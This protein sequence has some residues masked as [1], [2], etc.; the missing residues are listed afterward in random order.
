[1]ADS[2]NLK[3]KAEKLAGFTCFAVALLM[4]LLVT[5]GLNAA[6]PKPR[7]IVTTDGEIDDFCSMT[8]FLLYTSDFDVEGLIYSSSIFHW[9]GHQWAGTNW[10]QEK[11]NLYGQSYSNLSA[12]KSGYPTAA[13]LL[14]KVYIG[15]INSAGDM[16]ADT[17]GSNRIVDVLRDG[18]PRP[19][20]ILMWGGTNTAA[21]ALYHIQQNYPSE[22]A[23]ISQKA[24]L[25]IGL[26]QDNTLESY[27]RPN[28]PDL[29]VIC[30]Y[31]IWMAIGYVPQ[32]YVSDSSKLTYYSDSWM[33]SNITSNHGPLLSARPQASVGTF[34]G[35]GDSIT[36]LYLM[37]VGFFNQSNPGYGC[38][39]GRYKNQ[40]NSS[41]YWEDDWDDEEF[42][43]S[44]WR[45]IDAYQNDYAARADWCVKAYANCNHPP[46]VNDYE[47]INSSPGQ[48]VNLTVSASDP[49]GNALSYQ[50]WYYKEAGSY[51]GSAI[52][53]SNATSSNASFTVPS[54]SG[55]GQVIHMICSVT[56][57]GTPPLTRYRRVIINVTSGTPNIPALG[58]FVMGINF[59]GNAVTVEGNTWKSMSQALSSGLS[60]QSGYFNLNRPE[61]P[62]PDPGGDTKAMLMSSTEM[63]EADMSISQ[64][65]TNGDYVLFFWIF[66]WGDFYW[67]FNRNFTIYLEGQPK[68]YSAGVLKDGRW[69]KYGPIPVTVSDGTLNILLDKILRDPHLMGMSIHKANS[70]GDFDSDGELGAG[71]IDLLL[72]QINAGTHNSG[73]DLTGDGFVTQADADHWVFNLA[74]TR[75]GDADI[76]GDLDIDDILALSA[77][78][79]SSGIGWA[80][81]NFN[82]DTSADLHDLA[83]QSH[84]W[85]FDGVSVSITATDAIAS[86]AGLDPGTFTVWRNDTVGDLTVYYTVGGTASPVSSGSGATAVTT[87]SSSPSMD[88]AGPAATIDSSL[89]TRWLSVFDQG[90]ADP[91]ISWEFASTITL[92]SMDVSNYAESGQDRRGMK[93]VDIYI[94][95]GGVWVIWAD[96]Y[97]LDPQTGNSNTGVWT[98]TIDFEGVSCAGVKFDPKNNYYT[99]SPEI[100]GWGTNFWFEGRTQYPAAINDHNALTGLMEVAFFVNTSPSDYQELTGSLLIPN[101]Q[102]AATI[103]AIPNDD[104]EAEGNETVMVTL[105]ED[106]SY[107][108]GSPASATVTIMDND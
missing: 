94:K 54:D 52:S 99:A 79:L 97:K 93:Y 10:I 35:E 102:N 25:I 92:S 29:T 12:N 13:T 41:T 4:I 68:V 60:V 36:F 85:L 1:M 44:V 100:P 108:I 104:S 43:K 20:W 9:N 80:G 64:T 72:A 19:V 103:M 48:N 83:L 101:G 51:H 61:V 88:P 23:A 16:S 86:E 63:S 3:G 38:W 32:Y 40:H 42:A 81:G 75:Y 21:R 47:T 28:W 84:H 11:I 74:D 15:N 70:T 17:A 66:E 106:A 37:P 53:I 82:G 67:G 62:Y 59:G 96:D 78:W 14:S 73:Y 45:W 69:H 105:T 5:V 33:L 65:L 87:V 89:S 50:W 90:E 24:K 26:D 18:D 71:D 30:D 55:A 31:G 58:P 107:T 76:D 39:G 34:V 56:D 6:E 2:R 95:Q 49:D 7:V 57:N 22:M 46:V 77:N 91:W 27:V 8:R 98:D